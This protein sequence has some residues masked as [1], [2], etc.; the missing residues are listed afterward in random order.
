M[1]MLLDAK[2]LTCAYSIFMIIRLPKFSVLSELFHYLCKVSLKRRVMESSKQL[3]M[4]MEFGIS[5]VLKK[6]TGA[7]MQN[8]H[9]TNKARN[10]MP[11]N[12]SR[13]AGYCYSFNG[14][15]FSSAA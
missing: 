5:D 4:W 6:K 1:T 8:H 7:G 15:N 2:P 14:T 10:T 13:L 11:I 3:Q 9:Q 12:Q